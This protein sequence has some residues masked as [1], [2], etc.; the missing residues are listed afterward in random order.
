M[1]VECVRTYLARAHRN[2]G[3]NPPVLR[4]MA[5]AHDRNNRITPLKFTHAACNG[6]MRTA[7]LEW[8]LEQLVC[9]QEPQRRASVWLVDFDDHANSIAGK[10]FHLGAEV[11]TLLRSVFAVKETGKD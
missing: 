7:Y 10:M 3:S 5:C 11:T 6:T 4:S 9:F 1:I 2:P 8:A